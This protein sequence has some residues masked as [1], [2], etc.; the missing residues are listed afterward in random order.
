MLRINCKILPSH[1]YKSKSRNYSSNSVKNNKLI[2]EISKQCVLDNTRH[3]FVYE[4]ENILSGMCNEEKNMSYED[5]HSQYLLVLKELV[6]R[7]Y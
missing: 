7:N 6:N 1:V 5:G 4:V 3:N 2:D